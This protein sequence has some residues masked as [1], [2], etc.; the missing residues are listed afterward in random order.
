MLFFDLKHL[1]LFDGLKELDLRFITKT[2]TGKLYGDRHL[3]SCQ[4]IW[5]KVFFVH[6]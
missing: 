6:A 5:I 4:Q 1:F 3:H 2:P